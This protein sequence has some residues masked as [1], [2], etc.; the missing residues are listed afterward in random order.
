MK[1]RTPGENDSATNRIGNMHQHVY[2]VHL[3][4]DDLGVRE[5]CFLALSLA[6]LRLGS[7]NTAGTRQFL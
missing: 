1:T 3:W 4:D 6:R 2:L 7:T 5:V